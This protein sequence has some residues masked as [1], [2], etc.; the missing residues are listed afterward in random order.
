MRIFSLHFW[1]KNCLWQKGHNIATCMYPNKDSPTFIHLHQ[2]YTYTHLLGVLV[3]HFLPWFFPPVWLSSLW[4][5]SSV[6]T[7]FSRSRRRCWALVPVWLCKPWASCNP[8]GR[9]KITQY[10]RYL[11]TWKIWNKMKA[12]LSTTYSILLCIILTSI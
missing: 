6:P 3:Y 11:R 2:P 8:E 9:N 1:K 7:P 12:S 5:P 4:Q 10:N